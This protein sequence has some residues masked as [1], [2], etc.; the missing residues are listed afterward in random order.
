[1]SQQQEY[2][3]FTIA[4]QLKRR[5]RII[6][7]SLYRD[8]ERAYILQILLLKREAVEQVKIV[9]EINSVTIH[10]DPE[11][12]PKHNLLNLLNTVLANFAQKPSESIKKIVKHSARPGAVRQEIVFGVGGMSCASCALFL[13]MVLSREADNVRVNINYISEIGTVSTFL[14][15][16][17]IFKIVEDN[18]FQ[19]YSIDTLS[20]RKLLLEHE[21]K[22]LQIARKRLLSIS[23]LAVPT[24]LIR[25]VPS[26]GIKLRLMRAVL[27]FA[28]VFGGG[29]DVFKKAWIQLWQRNI[30]MDS[31][32]AIGAGSAYLVS[33]PSI[34]KP[35]RHNYF[36]AATVII[37]FVQLGRYL[38]ELAKNKMVHEVEALVNMQ[39]QNATLL[40]D[41]QEIQL[42]VDQIQLDDVL[43]IRPGERIPVDGMVIS[44]LSSVDESMIT[45]SN[46][47]SIK[48]KGRPLYDGSINGGGVLQMKATAIGKD[49]MLAGLVHMIDQTQGS[50]LQI[51]KTVDKISARLMPSIMILSAT[52]FVGW[53]IRG[54]G[55][56]HAFS[57]AVSVLLISCP[58]ALGLATPAATSVSSGQAARRKVYIRNGHA[59]EVMAAVDTVIFDKTGTLTEGQAKVVGFINIS[60]Y[61]EEHILQLAA[62][63][64][65][66]S[67]HLFGKAIVEYAREKDIDILESSRFYSIPDQGVRSQIAEDEVLLGNSAWLKQQDID[68]S[69]LQQASE[70]YASK[71]CTLIY[72][73]VNNQVVALFALLDQLR[74]GAEEL[75]QMLK[76]REM[77]VMLVTGDT[78][79]S[80]KPVAEKLKIDSRI[81]EASPAKKIQI[82]RELQTQGQIVAMIGDGVNDAPALAA[83]DVSLVVGNASGIAIEAADFVLV[84][85]DI[86]KVAE[87]MDLSHETLAIVKQNLF[88][89]FAY[90]AFAIPVAMA[91]RLNPMISSA[92]MA[93]SSV[94]VIVNSLRLSKK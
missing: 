59:P 74:T 7:P 43:L 47:P 78:E 85:G 70:K 66:N 80:A 21:Q 2:S 54:V 45:G 25:F 61:G 41:G 5:I 48:E 77:D 81:V 68:L 63:V 88:W 79:A 75:L 34:F 22:H 18:G 13:E 83:A 23:A 12:F 29:G 32:V 53:L 89:S 3:Q 91:G 62:S 8:K 90:N 11:K 33:L 49:T 20:E 86:A 14:S 44:G 10:F 24:M 67:E 87:M 94:T 93:F 73:V 31:L 84:D 15:K 71:A 30:N 4:H 69:D 76:Q 17:E 27:S 82:I 9:S 92:A 16:Q 52:T 60:D 38:E 37:G 42:A 40:K 56:A 46:M 57:N 36:D 55:M 50:K 64:E 72:L 58:C 39:P 65:F 35:Q 6:A 28:V 26:A 1:M 51:Q 19:A